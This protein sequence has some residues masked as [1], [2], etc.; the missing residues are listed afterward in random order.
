MRAA[1]RAEPDRPARPAP[2]VARRQGRSE[3]R[4]PARLAPVGP[5]SRARRSPARHPELFA[6]ARQSLDLPRRRRHGLEHGLEDQLLGALARRRPRPPDA[7]NQLKPASAGRH[8]NGGGTYPNL[9]DAHPPF[10]ID[11]NFGGTAGIA[12]MLLQSHMGSVS[13]RDRPAAGTSRAWKTG[14]VTG[15]RDRGGYEV[16]SVGKTESSPQQRSSRLL[17]RPLKLRCGQKEME[18]KTEAGKEYSIDGQL[19][20]RL[21]SIASCGRV[22][23]ECTAGCQRFVALP[24]HP[25][26]AAFSARRE[27]RL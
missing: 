17:G 10:Q 4:P 23:R 11:G 25:T 3:E 18:M 26:A 5:L 27:R 15:L 13:P 21:T 8:E 6:A 20:L 14:H 16:E 1:D 7:T 19:S 24:G 9:F 2:G 22:I 12:E